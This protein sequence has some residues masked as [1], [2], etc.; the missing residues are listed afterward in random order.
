MGTIEASA[1]TL[2]R[3]A[4]LTAEEYM[5]EAIERIDKS[6]GQ[7]YAKKNPNLVAAFMKV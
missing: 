6:F 4:S 7:G 3:Q 5:T 1:D 2:L